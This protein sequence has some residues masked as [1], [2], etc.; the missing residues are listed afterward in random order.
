MSLRYEWSQ[1]IY[2][3]NDVAG[4]KT[5]NQQKRYRKMFGTSVQEK[6][7]YGWLGSFIHFN[8]D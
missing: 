2:V 6:I 3:Q 7:I 5:E 4:Q 8:K 1:C